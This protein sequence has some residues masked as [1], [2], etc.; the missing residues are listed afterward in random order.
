MPA[1]ASCG[2][3]NAKAW[4]A[5]RLAKIPTDDFTIDVTIVLD[6]DALPDALPVPLTT[7]FSAPLLM[8]H[9]PYG[10]RFLQR[11]CCDPEDSCHP[12]TKS[13][14]NMIKYVL[15]GWPVE[16]SNEINL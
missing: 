16:I 13:F 6:T 8:A 5:I 11:L 9:L 1:G 3:I 7:E 14:L 2:A 10:V 15:T 4:D 12:L